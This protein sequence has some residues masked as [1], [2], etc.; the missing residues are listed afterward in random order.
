MCVRRICR[1]SCL[2]YISLMACYRNSSK[3]HFRTA[4]ATALVQGT[5]ELGAPSPEHMEGSN[6]DSSGA[7]KTV[8]S[9]THKSLSNA[10]RSTPS[11]AKKSA[12]SKK[13]F[14]CLQD[15]CLNVYKQLS[16]LRYHLSRVRSCFTIHSISLPYPSQSLQ[17]RSRGLPLIFFHTFTLCLRSDTCAWS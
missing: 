10:A 14:P 3:A 2:D 1:Y 16:G 8:D 4:I 5:S 13:T 15:G 17:L 6:S 9:R 7:E 11:L 12:K